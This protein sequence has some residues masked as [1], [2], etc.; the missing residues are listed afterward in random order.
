MISLCLAAKTLVLKETV[1]QSIWKEM[2]WP[3]LI[4]SFVAD[5]Q[6]YLLQDPTLPTWNKVICAHY[7]RLIHFLNLKST[8]LIWDNYLW[9]S[10]CKSASL[11]P[12]ANR[13][14]D[15]SYPSIEEEG[16]LIFFFKHSKKNSINITKWIEAFQIFVAVYNEKSPHES[17]TTYAQ[18]IQNIANTCWDQ[19]AL[20]WWKVHKMERKGF[21]CLS[22][23]R[24]KKKSWVVPISC[25]NRPRLQITKQEA[26]V[27]SWLNQHK[28][29][30][31]DCDLRQV[32]LYE[33][34]FTARKN[35]ILSSFSRRKMWICFP[36]RQ[37]QKQQDKIDNQEWLVYT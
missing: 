30:L 26:A 25:C 4:T 34:R 7:G 21:C 36:R 13:P 6:I 28:Y 37:R 29:L 35:F 9:G 14:T 10:K 33:V 17:L 22:L 31:N 19:A 3:T 27:R 8:W 12:P 15:N 2:T 1:H 32:C 16:Q 23:P 5:P 20:L 24:F 11:L 18:T